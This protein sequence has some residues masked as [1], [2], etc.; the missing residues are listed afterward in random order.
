[1][2][3]PPP[4]ASGPVFCL[5]SLGCTMAELTAA[6]KHEVSHRGKVLREPAVWLE[7]KHERA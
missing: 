4:P 1:P 2:P 5:P 3:P 7:R 6:Q